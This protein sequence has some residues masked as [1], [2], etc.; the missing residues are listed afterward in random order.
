MGNILHFFPVKTMRAAPLSSQAE[1]FY[2]L[3]IIEHIGKI[4]DSSQMR[5]ETL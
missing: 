5:A 1:A 2:T 4:L 3:K